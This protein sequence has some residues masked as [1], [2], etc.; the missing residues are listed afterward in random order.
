MQ[1][2]RKI[3]KRALKALSSPGARLFVSVVSIWEILLKRHAGKLLTT[4]DPDVIVQTIR[5][6]DTWRILPLETDHIQ[7]LNA[8]ARF[9]DHADPFDRILIAQA[10]SEKLS[11]MTADAQ[12]SRYGV[13]IVW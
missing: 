5:S 10:R 1:E 2:E 11:I 9:S 3:S 4:I 6:S 7:A 13:E 12:F 8:I